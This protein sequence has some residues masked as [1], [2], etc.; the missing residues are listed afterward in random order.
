MDRKPRRTIESDM[1]LLEGAKVPVPDSLEAARAAARSCTRCDLYKFGT[2][3][4]FG[5][6]PS[7]AQV[8][9]VG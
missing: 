5:E 3:T 8:M 7:K 1:P 4:V 9:F 2:Q 6:G